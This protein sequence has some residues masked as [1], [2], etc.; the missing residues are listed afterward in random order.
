MGQQSPFSPQGQFPY[1]QS[2][3]ALQALPYAFPGTGF[4]AP[5][6]NMMPGSALPAGG[7]PGMPPNPGAIAGV[8]PAMM[9]AAQQSLA[10]PDAGDV[11]SILPTP[12]ALVEG[13]LAGGAVA[14][15]MNYLTKKD[16][17]NTGARWLDKIPGAAW[18]GKTIDPHLKSFAENHPRF[19]EF[20]MPDAHLP[21]NA[22]EA[23]ID[24]AIKSAMKHME[25][26]QL[27]NV[28]GPYQKQF[29]KQPTAIQNEYA[30]VLKALEHS[31]PQPYLKSFAENQVVHP[32]ATLSQVVTDLEQQLEHLKKQDNKTKEQK[33]LAKTLRHLKE[34][35]SGI[36]N[37]YKPLYESQAHLTAKLSAEGVGP[38]G[39]GFAGFTNYIQRIFNGTTM[40]IG[41]ENE[42][43]HAAEENIFKKG[44]GLVQKAAGPLIAGLV[45]FGMSFHAANNAQDGEKNKTFFHNLLGSQIFNFIGWEFGRKV[46][47]SFQFG[48]KVF[49][50][51][52]GKTLPGFISKIPLV[53]LVG[54]ITLAGLG[55]E[56]VA[57]LLFGSLF[58]KVGEKLSGAIFGAPSQASIDGKGKNQNQQ[59]QGNPALQGMINPA[60]MGPAM[61]SALPAQPALAANGT[62][63]ASS[64]LMP[65]SMAATPMAPNQFAPT[66][67]PRATTA[68][69]TQPTAPQPRKFS[70][71]P[72]QIRNSQVATE[73]DDYYKKLKADKS[74][75][76][77]PGRLLDKS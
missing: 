24:T 48:S 60:W 64:P 11:S 25:Q 63:G 75:D 50:R 19:K 58:Q 67:L 73:Y 59:G 77:R 42:A 47:N 18:L 27:T 70:L 2:L 10:N 26:N 23:D 52:A 28:L 55:T 15:G 20:L 31:E 22:S 34:R 17:F 1:A 53:G 30:K 66:A 38:I 46:L 41:A 68:A 76:K 65:A 43:T 62:W 9:S 49:G 13:A 69:P 14:L 56:L 7:Q 4:A 8:D 33:A 39:R 45:I 72:D 12:K 37:L 35:V 57:M 40:R 5:A 6:A 32:E 21:A 61:G 16:V 29:I 71:T 3:P 36:N 54:G 74:L 51:V 44:W